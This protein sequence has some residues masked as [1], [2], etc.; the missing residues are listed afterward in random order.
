MTWP[1]EHDPVFGCLL[2][3]GRLDKD[4]YPL[5]DDGKRAHRVVYESEHGPIPRGFELD[6]G[7]RRRRCVKHLEPVTRQENERRKIFRYRTQIKLCAAG[8]PQ[9]SYTRILTPEGGLV[10]RTC[11][12]G[13]Q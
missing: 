6:H 5:T 3:T 13:E 9:S 2:W 12:D 8:H 1:V 11:R 4:G 10:C 7:C